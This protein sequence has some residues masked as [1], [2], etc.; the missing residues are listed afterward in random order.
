M[1][2]L[3]VSYSFVIKES[4]QVLFKGMFENISV[5]NLDELE[6]IKKAQL[7][8]ADF[9][10]ID[11][12]EDELKII[13]WLSEIKKYFSDIKMMVFDRSKEAKVLKKTIEVGVE[14]YVYNINE[15]D[16]FIYTINRILKGKKVYAP[17]LLK[18][19]LQ[20][21][22]DNYINE[23]TPRENEVRELVE[24]G[25][26]NKEV[27]EKLCITEYTVKK[28]VSSILNKLDLKNRKELI[29]YATRSIA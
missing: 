4:L 23:L 25:L 28:H 3:V 6:A 18:E 7:Q 21:K 15:K 9:M 14:G 17:E 20:S 19:I 12:D 2:I 8:K 29:L 5:E 13:G 11:L 22:I 26:E 16:D 1:N 24:Q 27:A 10:F